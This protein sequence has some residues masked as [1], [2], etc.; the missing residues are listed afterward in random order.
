M[1]N[2]NTETLPEEEE[3]ERY[4]AHLTQQNLW[5]PVMPGDPD[6]NPDDPDEA[7]RWTGVGSPNVLV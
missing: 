2:D 6:Y 1:T 5:V 3:D 4:Q 7:L